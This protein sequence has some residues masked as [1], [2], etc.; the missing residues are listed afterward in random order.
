MSVGISEFAKRQ[1]KESRFSHF[2]GSWED[3]CTL[4]EEYICN[5]R[6]G[7]RGGVILVSVPPKGFF[8]SVIEAKENLELESHFQARQDEEDP[9]LFTVAKGAEKVPAKRVEIVLYRHDVLDE[10]GD[11]STDE[12]WEIVSINASPCEEEIPMS[13]MTRARNILHLQGGTDAKIEDL[14]K[15]ELIDL[16][17]RMAEEVV[18]WSTHV[19]V[20]EKG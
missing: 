2:E 1:T 8:S 10:D 16:V 4:V 15:N 6:Q 11:R 17:K 12:E 5:S 7:Y 20:G 13:P 18:F 3:L 19:Q 14:S 9:V